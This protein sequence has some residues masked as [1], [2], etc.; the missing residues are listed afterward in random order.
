MYAKN[1]QKKIIEPIEKEGI[2][3]SNDEVNLQ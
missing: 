1:K 2:P 3:E